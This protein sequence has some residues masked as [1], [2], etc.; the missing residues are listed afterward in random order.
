LVDHKVPTD[1][2]FF[3]PEQVVTIIDIF[4]TISGTLKDSVTGLDIVPGPGGVNAVTA[5][6][7]CDEDGKFQWIFGP[8]FASILSLDKLNTTVLPPGR[9]L[10]W[11]DIDG[12]VPAG[13][14]VNVPVAG[15]INFNLILTPIPPGFAAFTLFKLVLYAST[16][17]G[18]FLSTDYYHDN[19]VSITILNTTTGLPET[20]TWSG[21]RPFNW[22]TTKVV[23]IGTVYDATGQ[24]LVD[25]G[26]CYFTTPFDWGTKTIDANKTES[27]VFVPYAVVSGLPDEEVW[28][29]LERCAAVVCA[30]PSTSDLGEQSDGIAVS[31]AGFGCDGLDTVL[32]F[33]IAWNSVNNL[34]PRTIDLFVRT[35]PNTRVLL[36]SYVI[37]L[38]GPVGTTGVVNIVIPPADVIMLQAINF[39]NATSLWIQWI[40]NTGL[41]LSGLD[42][43]QTINVPPSCVP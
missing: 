30:P 32:V 6:H 28:A 42:Q 21:T 43:L 36:L 19:P 9:W 31:E 38:V 39:P 35:G 27:M 41:S 11:F 20:F 7:L 25:P 33:N 26:D 16:Q 29:W 22:W 2:Y 3:E 10:I 8:R 24:Q 5:F 18:F 13:I 23:P 40:S 17:G 1:G 37:N 14:V 34:G 15:T 12:Y 4:G